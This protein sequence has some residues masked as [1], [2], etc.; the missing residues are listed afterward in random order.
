MEDPASKSDEFLKEVAAAQSPEELE[1]VRITLLG[2]N[3]AITS[4]MR[5][6]GQ[7]PAEQRRAAGATLNSLRDTV[8]AA[9]E[10]AGDRL[11]RAA[12]ANRL[13]GERADVSLP[14]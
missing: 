2:R 14:V 6:L 12:L 11:R 1:Q 8:T 7:L 13:A 4:L 5:G 3:G 9:L 10:E